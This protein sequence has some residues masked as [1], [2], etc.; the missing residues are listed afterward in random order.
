LAGCH[1]QRIERAF[2]SND[3]KEQNSSNETSTSPKRSRQDRVL[4]I[5]Q[6]DAPSAQHIEGRT[7]QGG[8]TREESAGTRKGR[9]RIP[10][11]FKEVLADVLKVK[12]PGNKR[13]RQTTKRKVE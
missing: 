9:S 12:P 10:L 7:I 5:R 11:P 4:E 3:I 13:P 8:S 1:H 6:R 2:G